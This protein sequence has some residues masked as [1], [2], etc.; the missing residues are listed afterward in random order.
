[1]NN[2]FEKTKCIIIKIAVEAMIISISIAFYI[3]T[4]KCIEHLR[5]V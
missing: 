4:Y 1:M 2:I 5:W 3:F